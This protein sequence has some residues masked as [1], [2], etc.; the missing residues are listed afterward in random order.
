MA[1]PVVEID[2]DKE[3][4]QEEKETKTEVKSSFNT[5]SKFMVAKPILAKPMTTANHL[6]RKRQEKAEENSGTAV[7]GATGTAKSSIM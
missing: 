5:S 6:E 2:K 7:A 4:N 1:V 3:K